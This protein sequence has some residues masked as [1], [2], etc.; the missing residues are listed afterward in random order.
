MVEP[1]SAIQPPFDINLPWS[2][3]Y[4]SK[5]AF[6]APWG[7]FFTHSFM[8]SQHTATRYIKIIYTFKLLDKVNLMTYK[9]LEPLETFD[10]F[11]SGHTK[12]REYYVCMLSNGFV[13]VKLVD[14]IARVPKVIRFSTTKETDTNPRSN[15][16]NLVRLQ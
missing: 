4:I 16:P 12:K 13:S 7:N 5:L 11:I 2:L 15:M 1:P 3:G 6:G 9:E 10:L 8:C 14:R